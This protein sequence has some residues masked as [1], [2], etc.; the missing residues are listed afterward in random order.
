MP[1][2]GSGAELWLP[3]PKAG[4]ADSANLRLW[5]TSEYSG[6]KP[7]ESG[8]QGRLE[9]SADQ[10]IYG[11]GWDP[12]ESSVPEM[13]SGGNRGPQSGGETKV[14]PAM[15]EDIGAQED[16][17]V[18]DKSEWPAHLDVVVKESNL[19]LRSLYNWF[20]ENGHEYEARKVIR[21]ASI[22]ER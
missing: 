8:Q 6:G 4:E 5:M 21:L 18:D 1:L 11:S 10:S 13:G 9:P 14:T 7:K 20:L 15:P 22:R 16:S 3:I 2:G 19:K 12:E 17:A